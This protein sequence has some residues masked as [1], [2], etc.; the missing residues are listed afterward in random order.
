MKL[1]GVLR[2]PPVDNG[3]DLFWIDSEA[4]GRDN[5]TKAKN[6]IKLEFTFREL[7]VEL[8]FSE[9]VK[10]HLQMFS[11]I[12]FILGEHQDI[13]EIHQGEFIGVGVEDEVHH[14]RESWR[15]IYK[16]ERHDSIF[17]RTKACSECC[18]GNILFTNANLMITHMKVKLG[19]NFSTF[20]LL[21]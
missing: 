5:V 21:E 9:L 19:E 14:T 7:C 18:L 12:L 3:S 20:E 17:I 10:H 2:R 11:M 16:A 15:G 6:F 4:L 13:I 8:I 1:L